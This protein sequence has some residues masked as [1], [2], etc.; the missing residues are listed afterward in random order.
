MNDQVL[1]QGQSQS[2]SSAFD[3]LVGEGKKFKDQNAL[4]ESKEASDAFIKTLEA[5]LDNATSD[6]RTLT[7]K[8]NSQA[9]MQELI[10][11]YTQLQKTQGT[12]T[13]QPQSQQSEK[14][15]LDLN[16]LEELVSKKVQNIEQSRVEQANLELVRN[17]IQQKWGEN[18]PTSVREQIDKLGDLGATMAKRYPDEFLRTIGA[19][20]TNRQP[21]FL[22]PPRASA[23]SDTLKPQ[24]SPERTWSW[25]ED[26]RKKSPNEY[27]S[28]KMT[29]QMHND[30]NSQGES[31]FDGDFNMDDKDLLR[32]KYNSSY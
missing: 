6:I 8:L 16:Q 9:N 2:P 13:Q 11:Q 14:P 1:P 28:R 25:Y 3:R 30:M 19:E 10:D 32:T 27:Y 5:K 18:V 26:L 31:F 29:V 12:N 22:S 21:N 4:A 15:T 24:G 17:K 23:N 7:E 20:V